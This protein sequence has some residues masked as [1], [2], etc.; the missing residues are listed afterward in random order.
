M[1]HRM[2]SGYGT[3]FYNRIV[4]VKS[5]DPIGKVLVPTHKL[6]FGIT[7]N[8]RWGHGKF[9][10]VTTN[11]DLKLPQVSTLVELKIMHYQD[12]KP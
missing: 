2:T 5:A 4:N 8:L 9:L 1:R 3:L 12:R 7:R 10:S 11:A 6:A